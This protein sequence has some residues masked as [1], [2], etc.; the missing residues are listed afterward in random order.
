MSEVIGAGF[1]GIDEMERGTVVPAIVAGAMLVNVDCEML[2]DSVR[3]SKRV[4][5]LKS[6]AT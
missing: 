2:L 3:G 5:L 4:S 6:V 1:G